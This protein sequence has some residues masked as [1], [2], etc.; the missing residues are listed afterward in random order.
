MYKFQLQ[1][2]IFTFRSDSIISQRINYDLLKTIHN[3]ETNK[4]SCPELLGPC[5]ISKT[6][7]TV[8]VAM[9]KAEN[10]PTPH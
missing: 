1:S 5:T 3:I 9:T 10:C 6:S 7:E 2:Y 8:P 4:I